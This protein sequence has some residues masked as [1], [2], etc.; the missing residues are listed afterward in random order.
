[1]QTWE[2]SKIISFLSYESSDI[3]DIIEECEN[4][5]RWMEEWNGLFKRLERFK[6][7]LFKYKKF[8]ENQRKG[9]KKGN[10]YD[11]IVGIRMFWKAGNINATKLQISG[12]FTDIRVFHSKSTLWRFIKDLREL[13]IPDHIINEC[14]IK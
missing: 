8:R 1:M 3:N 11:W 13:G 12:A 14:K 7:N 5:E 4:Y 9:K 10:R 6:R 2:L